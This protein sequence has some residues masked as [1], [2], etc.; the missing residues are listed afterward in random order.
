MAIDTVNEKLA[1]IVFGRTT[2]P[3]NIPT[4]PGSIGQDDK[5]QFL[6]GYPGLLWAAVTAAVEDVIRYY[7]LQRSRR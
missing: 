2:D 3:A 4:A 6:W 7:A 5:Q 1:L